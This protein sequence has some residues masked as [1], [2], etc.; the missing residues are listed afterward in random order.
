[1]KKI[2]W[3][4]IVLLIAVT[5]SAQD[6]YFTKTGKINFDATS[7][8]SPEQV[9][10]IHKSTLCVLDTKTGNLQFSVTMKGFEFERALM[11]EHFNENYIESDR[12]PK[13]V[14]KGKI[15]GFDLQSLTVN[16]KDFIIKGK[17]ELHG[18]SKE[19]SISATIKKAD[20][21]IEIKSDFALNTDDFNIEIPEIVIREPE[22]PIIVNK[23][24]KNPIPIIGEKSIVTIN[25]SVAFKVKTTELISMSDRTI[26]QLI[27]NLPK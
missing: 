27:I 13:A 15:E 10:G 11:Q 8:G 14:F 7:P 25:S 12:Y 1:M 2:S 21:G 24:I 23:T 9:E 5:V 6:K 17:L 16:P 20:N 3:L 18:K 19:I 4:L 26:K 22:P